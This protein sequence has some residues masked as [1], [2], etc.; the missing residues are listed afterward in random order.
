[1]N[2]L[3]RRAC[4]SN[5]VMTSLVSFKIAEQCHV[6]F[7][8]KLKIIVIFP[9]MIKKRAFDLTYLLKLKISRGINLDWVGAKKPKRNKHEICVKATQ[10]K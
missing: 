3:M 10:S 2:L 8:F 1:M 5:W 4:Q 6:I 7:C 9:K